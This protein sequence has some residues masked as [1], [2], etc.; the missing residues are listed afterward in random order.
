M[1]DATIIA[2]AAEKVLN[3]DE[4]KV[5]AF[6]RSMIPAGLA[7]ELAVQ[8]GTAAAAALAKAHAPPDGS[9]T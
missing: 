2:A 4:Q 3:D 7:H 6:E 9:K 5:P 8:I 1:D